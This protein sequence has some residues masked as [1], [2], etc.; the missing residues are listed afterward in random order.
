MQFCYTTDGRNKNVYCMQH[1]LSYNN[2]APTYNNITESEAY[3]KRNVK[4]K[5]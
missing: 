3:R 2:S 4:K 5:L 1:T